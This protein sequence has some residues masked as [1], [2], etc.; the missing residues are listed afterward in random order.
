MLNIEMMLTPLQVTNFI[1]GKSYTDSICMIDDEIGGYVNNGCE[2]VDE[3]AGKVICFME[4]KIS[5]EKL[6]QS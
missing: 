2:R 3:K 1:F 6:T 5:I 4:C